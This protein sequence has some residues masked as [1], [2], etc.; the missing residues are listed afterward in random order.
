MTAAFK[1]FIKLSIPPL[2]CGIIILFYHEVTKKDTSQIFFLESVSYILLVKLCACWNMR[3]YHQKVKFF[4][5]LLCVDCAKQH[6][7]RL[8]SHHCSRRKVCDCDQCFSNQFF[9][10]IKFMN[11]AQN[12]S[13]C[14]CTIIQNELKKLFALRYSCTFFYLNGSEIRFAER[15]KIYGICE[16]RLNFNF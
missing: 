7:T 10:L 6:T 13:V 14:A 12:S 3:I 16:K 8:N 4:F 5:S 2:L 11:T 15:I 9:R 1:K